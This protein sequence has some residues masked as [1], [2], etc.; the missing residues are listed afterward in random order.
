MGTGNDG[1]DV[2]VVVLVLVLVLVDEPMFF[3]HCNGAKAS[4]VTLLPRMVVRHRNSK[5][6]ERLMVDCAVFV[7]VNVYDVSKVGKR[8]SAVAI[9]VVVDFRFQC[10]VSQSS[11]TKPSHEIPIDGRL[12]TART[13]FNFKML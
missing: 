12:K 1:Q 2:L 5:I 11:V 4:Q 6:Q 10:S 13:V 9:V 7:L 8:H 3:E